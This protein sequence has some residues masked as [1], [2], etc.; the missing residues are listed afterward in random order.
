MSSCW[1]HDALWLI[2]VKKYFRGDEF[3][4][5]K[6]SQKDPLNLSE[7]PKNLWIHMVPDLRFDAFDT[8]ETITSQE[9]LRLK[10]EAQKIRIQKAKITKLSTSRVLK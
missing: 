4:S 3:F 5:S 8:V 1:A 6:M 2:I 9:K 10:L 7:G